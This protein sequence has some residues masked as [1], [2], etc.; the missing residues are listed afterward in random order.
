MSRVFVFVCGSKRW[1]SQSSRG[2]LPYVLLHNTARA[3]TRNLAELRAVPT[4]RFLLSR[5]SHAS[6]Q[7][8]LSISFGG[9]F[10]G[11]RERGG[12]GVGSRGGVDSRGGGVVFRG[13]AAGGGFDLGT[14][15]GGGQSGQARSAS[16]RC[17]YAG[18]ADGGRV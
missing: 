11:V 9:G 10:V 8:P 17:R 6:S 13:F 3:P 4:H 15:C 14:P 18:A 12:G 1:C 5:S 2:E 7:S 16:L